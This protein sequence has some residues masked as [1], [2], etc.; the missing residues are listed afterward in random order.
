[1][2]CF[3]RSF[4]YWSER[5]EMKNLQVKEQALSST[6]QPNPTVIFE[7]LNRY[8]QSMALKGAI[9]LELFT[10][11]A[12]G[13]RTPEGIA[14]RCQASE[15]GVRI[16]CDFLTVMKVLTKANGA[17][18]LTSDSAVFLNKRSPAYLGTIADFILSDGRRSRFDDV[19]ALVRKGGTLD[20][21]GTMEPE[22]DVWVDFARAMK[23]LAAMAGQLVARMVSEPGSRIKVLDVA[24]GHGMFGISVAQCNPAAEIFAVDWKNVL[25]IATENAAIAG[26]QSRYHTLPGSV[27]DVSL[28]TGYDLVLI[29]NFLH[30]FDEATN[31]EL[32]RRIRTAMT[33]R[34]R[35]ATLEFVPNEDRVTPP[36]AASFSLV[37]LGNTE[38]GDA[39]TF[40]EFDA[41]FRQAGFGDSS[42]QDLEPTP[43]R[44]I[45]TSM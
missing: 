33:P 43:Q 31:V 18:A 27:F 13:A 40:R 30:H 35:V 14:A 10:H 45:L 32:L 11:I 42:L 36:V 34:G 37:M 41:M 44:L 38:R 22:S 3:T 1:M 25:K 26:V 15:R 28:G 23:P 21:A 19:A 6:Q 4:R 24:A 5:G 39:Y 20:G 9:D 12:T 2:S 7:T 8:Q 16:L 17:Y 29:P